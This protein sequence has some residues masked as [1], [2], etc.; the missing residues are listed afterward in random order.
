MSDCFKKEKQ[1]AILILSI[2]AYYLLLRL[3]RFSVEYQS[4]I[5]ALFWL[6]I[7]TYIFFCEKPN[8]HS[9]LKFT[10]FY[11]LLMLVCAVLYLISYFLIGTIDGFGLNIYDTSYI[12]ITRNIIVLGSAVI[13]K[14]WVRNYLI[15]SVQ[16]RFV[17][18]FGVII[19]L[20][21]SFTEVNL[22][23]FSKLKTLEEWFSYIS[24]NI[25][26]VVFFNVF[27]TFAAYIL[28]FYGTAIYAVLTKFPI[29]VVRILPNFR[30]ITLL[31]VGALLPLMFTIVL[32]SISRKKATRGKRLEMKQASPYSWI[33]TAV[34]AVLTVWFALG[35][36][37]I[38]PKAIVSNSMKPD[39]SRGDI[40]L[41]QKVDSNSLKEQDVVLYALDNIQVFHRIIKI[42]YVQ[43]V[44]QYTVKGD[45]NNYP[46][47][48]PVL[49]E[50]IIGKHI[51]TIPYIGWPGVLLQQSGGD[52]QV[53]TGGT[54]PTFL[55]KL[56]SKYID[57]QTQNSDGQGKGD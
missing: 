14:E 56:A 27:M 55:D 43:G 36:F 49:G 18:V 19:I 40:V 37:P 32:R 22:D 52:V 48:K 1:V 13:L 31:L 41:I 17:V 28:G 15:N 10:E 29:W 54:E 3:I 38:F 50:Q 47:P 12:G 23:T 8:L 44:K 33:A 21:F 30:W 53:E 46:D 35:I 51:A 4:V 2:L 11:L 57:S 42:K 26:P 45:N 16:K 25:L 24:K 5:T 34:I 9:K 7:A 6:L 20:I 39:I